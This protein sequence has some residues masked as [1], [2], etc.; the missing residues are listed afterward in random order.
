[1]NTE[2]IEINPDD[3][4]AHFLLGGA[5][6]ELGRYEEAT[7]SYKQAIEIDPDYA[8]AHNNLACRYS[9][10]GNINKALKFLGKAID[11]GFND[12]KY[13]ENDS[14]FNRLRDEAG[15]NLLK[16]QMLINKKR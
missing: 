4:K 9:L 3:A 13:I 6:Y 8:D 1:M 7:E 2:A 12:I 14:D 16:T 5:Y 11:S 15:Y 10:L